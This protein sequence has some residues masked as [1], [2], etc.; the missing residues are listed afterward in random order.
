[1]N[2]EG[3]RGEEE[4]K[5]AEIVGGGRQDDSHREDLDLVV[6]CHLAW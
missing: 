1:M 5:D 4:K 3:M 6:I 2:D